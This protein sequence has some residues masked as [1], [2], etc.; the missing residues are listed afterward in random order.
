MINS[1]AFMRLTD[2]VK[3]IAENASAICANASESVQDARSRTRTSATGSDNG[4]HR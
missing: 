4:G 2:S 1:S 3:Q